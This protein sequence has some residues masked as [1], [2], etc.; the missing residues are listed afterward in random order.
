M[1]LSVMPAVTAPF[2]RAAWVSMGQTTFDWNCGGT[3][4]LIWEKRYSLFPKVPDT[5][6]N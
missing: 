3:Q 5:K 6:T 2:T 4:F 1:V